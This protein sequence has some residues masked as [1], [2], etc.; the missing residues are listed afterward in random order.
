MKG[1]LSQVPHDKNVNTKAF[2][3]VLVEPENSN[4]SILTCFFFSKSATKFT[5]QSQNLTANITPALEQVV[6]TY[7]PVLAG[8][9][10]AC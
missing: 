10:L 9:R 4:E 6:E 1:F 2:F 7:V 5:K 3:F 8:K